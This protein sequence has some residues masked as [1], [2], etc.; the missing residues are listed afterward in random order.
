MNKGFTL[1]E[2]LIVI[3]II[4]ILAAISY[5]SY[6]EYVLRGN[7]SEGKAFLLDASARQ[8]RFFSQ[9]N[10]YTVTASDLGLVGNSTSN[11]YRLRIQ[12]SDANNGG[13]SLIAV[14]NFADTA[15]GNLTLNA[16]GVRGRS[17]TGKTVDECWR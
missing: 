11:K 7:R 12:P 10:T 8:E 2:L 13:Y 4:G 5:P 1:I 17:G 6:Q 15:C 9:N 3:A 14:P 16:L